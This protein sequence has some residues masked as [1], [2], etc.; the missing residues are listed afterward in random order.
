[1]LENISNMLAGIRWLQ[2]KSSGELW[3]RLRVGLQYAICALHWLEWLIEW[4]M[5]GC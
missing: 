3:S 5:A 1:M 4:W 2:Y